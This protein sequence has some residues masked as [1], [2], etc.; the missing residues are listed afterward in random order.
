MSNILSFEHWNKSNNSSL[1]ESTEA[2]LTNY[3]MLELEKRKVEFDHWITG[4]VFA[5][6]LENLLRI[7][8]TK[9]SIKPFK[10][11]ILKDKKIMNNI[12]SIFINHI[13]EAKDYLAKKGYAHPKEVDLQAILKHQMPEI[14]QEIEDLFE[15]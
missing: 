13:K 2:Y 1:N 14:L 8:F 4:G 7:I 12:S 6:S 10:K 3:I 9:K 15:E 11:R 5:K